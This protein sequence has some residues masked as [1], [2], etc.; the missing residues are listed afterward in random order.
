MKV[1]MIGAGY[2]GLVSGAC[3][4]EFGHHVICIDQ[5]QARIDSLRRGIMPIFEPGLDDLV[6]RNQAQGRLEFSG[7][8]KASVAGADLVFIAVG[9][10]SRRGDGHA[11]LGFVHEAARQIAVALTGYA[12]VVDKSTVP[13]GTG[14]AVAAIMHEANPRAEFDVASNPEFLREGSAIDDFMRPNRVV[15][16][17]ESDRAREVLRQLYRPLYLNETP[18]LHRAKTP[19][20][21]NAANAFLASLLHQPDV[22]SVR[23]AGRRRA[24]CGQ[25]HGPRPAHRAQVSASG[26]GLWRVLLSQGHAG[27]GRD[28]A[29]GGSARLPGR[30]RRC[31]QRGAQER[32]GRAH[33]SALAP[34][35]RKVIILA[36]PK[37]N[38]D[39]ATASLAA[40]RR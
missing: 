8:L 1:V 6:H 27:A 4:S 29:R 26:P 25:G 40:S 10:P 23:E 7:D 30:E 2:V 5:D 37:P 22:R 3:F 14:R 15:I 11:D 21:P 19:N 31:L 33:P 24:G 13:V 16:G 36:S 18:I 32:D 38:T 12:V 17:V 20:S 28:R 39:G 34:A 9:T 35:W